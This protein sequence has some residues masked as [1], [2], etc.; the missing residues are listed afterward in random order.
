[1]SSTEVT[2]LTVNAT[3]VRCVSDIASIA[4]NRIQQFA[5]KYGTGEQY[6]RQRIEQDLIFFM[7]KRNDLNL[8]QLEVHILEDGEVAVGSFNGRRKAS[9]ILNFNYLGK[10]YSR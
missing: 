5:E 9:L 6:N 8:T 3:E 10:G 7:V 2:S 1:M 4:A